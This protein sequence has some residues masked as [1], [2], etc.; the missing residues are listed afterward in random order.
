CHKPLNH[1]PQ[2][3]NHKPQT[4]HYL[5]QCFPSLQFS[6]WKNDSGSSTLARQSEYSSVCIAAPLSSMRTRVA[7]HPPPSATL[8]SSRTSWARPSG[9]GMS[10][11][12]NRVTISRA[13]S[14]Q[15][16]GDVVSLGDAEPTT[17]VGLPSHSCVRMRDKSILYG[18]SCLIVTSSG[19]RYTL[20]MSGRNGFPSARLRT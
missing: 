16:C 8:F 14:T 7:S 15:N 11:S 10:G 3:T 18:A 13:R 4:T 20:T 1:K 19:S 6:A 12:R 5:A 2:T 9:E 17:Y